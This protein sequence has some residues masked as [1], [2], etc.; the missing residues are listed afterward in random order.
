MLLGKQQE[1]LPL[2]PRLLLLYW[3]GAV[4]PFPRTCETP[5]PLLCEILKCFVLPIYIPSHRFLTAIAGTASCLRVAGQCGHN[6][7]R[8]LWYWAKTWQ[9]TVQWWESEEKVAQNPEAVSHLHTRA[10]V[11]QKLLGPKQ[12]HGAKLTSFNQL[13]LINQIKLLVHKPGLNVS[14]KPGRVC[15][16]SLSL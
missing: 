14:T 3:I 2:F 12:A 10:D 11:S 1:N 9:K 16:R 7:H 6:Q 15:S 13:I 8:L 5:V 4:S